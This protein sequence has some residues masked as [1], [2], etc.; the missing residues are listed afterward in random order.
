MLWMYLAE[1]HRHL[2]LLFPVHRARELLH[3][4]PAFMQNKKVGKGAREPGQYISTGP[5]GRSS[6]PTQ[7]QCIPSYAH[8]F[9]SVYTLS[10]HISLPHVAHAQQARDEG[11]GV[12]GV[13]VVEVLTRAFLRV[14]MGCVLVVREGGSGCGVVLYVIR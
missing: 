3:Q 4:A 8:T 11:L 10:K 5:D 6:E 2:L 14:Y 1:A 9:M 12:E 13:Q 7:R